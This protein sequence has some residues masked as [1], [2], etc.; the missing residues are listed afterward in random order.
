VSNF[1]ALYRI[2]LYTWSDL[3]SRKFVPFVA[4]YM[5]PEWSG[6]IV[7]SGTCMKLYTCKIVVSGSHDSLFWTM[8]LIELYCIQSFS[9]SSVCQLHLISFFSITCMTKSWTACMTKS[10]CMNQTKS[11]RSFVWSVTLCQVFMSLVSETK[12]LLSSYWSSWKICYQV[13]NLYWGPEKFI[14][15]KIE[16]LLHKPI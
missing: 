16:T 6:L 12:N 9:V 14:T 10:S 15:I 1:C 2:W 13:L 8:L 5:Y 4:I 7:V 11:F 3:L